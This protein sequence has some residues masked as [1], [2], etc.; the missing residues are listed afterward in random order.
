MKSKLILI[1]YKTLFIIL[2]LEIYEDKNIWSSINSNT[3]FYKEI[4]SLFSIVHGEIY[5]NNNYSID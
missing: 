1:K 3:N 2:N 4:E 5:S